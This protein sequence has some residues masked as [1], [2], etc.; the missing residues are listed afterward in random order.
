MPEF[1]L[2]FVLDCLQGSSHFVYCVIVTRQYFMVA[3]TCVVCSGS[4]GV[5]HE[6]E[7][8]CGQ[9]RCPSLGI[10]WQGHKLL[11]NLLNSKGLHNQELFVVCD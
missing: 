3:D 9:R 10:N 11:E 4:P 2:T 6:A 8:A 1:L 5:G 7:P